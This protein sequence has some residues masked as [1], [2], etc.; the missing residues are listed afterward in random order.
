MLAAI[1]SCP[2]LQSGSQNATTLQSTM[3][4]PIDDIRDRS[5]ARTNG[6]TF[7]GIAGQ[8]PDTRAD[9]CASDRPA[10]SHGRQ[11][12]GKQDHDTYTLH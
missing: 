9:G 1:V 12:Q 3:S 4:L 5:N 7:A 10:T 2:L 11:R 8:R 6:G